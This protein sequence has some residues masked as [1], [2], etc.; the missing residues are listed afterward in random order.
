LLVIRGEFLPQP[1]CA[2][3]HHHSAAAPA[4]RLAS[5]RCCDGRLCDR[6]VSAGAGP[7]PAAGG[8]LWAA[9]AGGGLSCLV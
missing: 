8:D 9:S 5:P 3:P 6:G 4:V 1:L 2:S 7:A